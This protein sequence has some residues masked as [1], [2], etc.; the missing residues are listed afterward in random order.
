[1]NFSL[2]L[3]GHLRTIRGKLKFAGHFYLKRR[4]DFRA[5]L[6]I[7]QIFPALQTVRSTGEHTGKIFP[8][9]DIFMRVCR[10]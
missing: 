1:V 8:A 7:P 9:T 10:L 5:R 4:G 6:T 3:T 2:P